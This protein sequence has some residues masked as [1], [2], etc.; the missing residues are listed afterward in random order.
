[1]NSKGKSGKSRA[2]RPSSGKARAARRRAE[3]AARRKGAVAGVIEDGEGVSQMTDD[4]GWWLTMRACLIRKALDVAG[5]G[6]WAGKRRGELG[7]GFSATMAAMVKGRRA[8]DALTD[9]M[10]LGEDEIWAEARGRLPAAYV[11]VVDSVLKAFSEMANE[12]H[13][14]FFA[15]WQFEMVG[16]PEDV[17]GI[18]LKAEYR[19]ASGGAVVTA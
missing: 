6:R 18:D 15:D 10:L 12:G 3:R 16:E 19:R 9:R 8:E 2:G 7:I 14:A 17:A 1:M 5:E 11:E 4:A 13:S